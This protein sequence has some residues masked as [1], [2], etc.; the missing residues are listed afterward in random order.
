MS[1]VSL[2]ANTSAWSDMAGSV[3]NGERL[4]RAHALQILDASD[5][6]LLAILDAA[7]RVR[8]QHFGN[9]VQ[10]YYLKNAKS[11]LCP[12]DCTYCSQSKVSDAPIEKYAMLNAERLL[13]G[14][15]KAFESQART[16]C[17]VASGRG[18]SDREVDHVCNVV[19]EIKQKY[20]LHICAC[21][22]LLRPNQAARLKEAGVDRVNHNLNT[23]ERHH[24]AIVTTHTF[25]DRLETLRVCRDAGLELCTGM[26]VGMGESHE[27]VVDVAMKLAELEVASI[28]INFLNSIDGTP[29]EHHADLDPRYCLKVL[30]MF[31]L[32]NP[33][34]ELR[35]AGGREVNLRSLQAMGLY[36]ANSM[37]VSDYLTT[38]GQQAQED[39]SMIEDL[40]FEITAGDY[41]SATAAGKVRVPMKAVLFDASGEPAEVLHCGDAAV[42]EPAPG[43]LRV[44]MLASPINPSDLMFVR[45]NYTITAECP[46]SPGFEGVG[47]VEASGGGLR[48]KLFQGRRVVVMN[49]KGGNW[50]EQVVVPATQVIPVSSALSD[51]Q[52]ATF[53]VNPATAWVM[54]QEILRIPR[55]AWL[56]Q[57]AA[58]SALGHMIVRLGRECGF[59]TLNI[60]RRDAHRES[61]ER[62]GADSVVVFD[63]VTDSPGQLEE[64]VRRVSDSSD[65]AYAID[66]VGGETAT[67]VL[68]C[69]SSGGRLLLYGT[70]SDRPISFSPR[71]LMQRSAR[72]EGF[73]LGQFMQQQNLLFKLKLVR[74]ITRMIQSGILATSVGGNYR[75]EAITEAVTRSESRDSTGKI[76]L[77]FPSE[78]TS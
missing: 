40:G 64:H 33:A 8:R 60:I 62:A 13:E 21:L 29:L 70:L 14:A 49:T 78:R 20:G 72:V 57:T 47:I 55:G 6:E 68:N 51:E 50:A 25:Q 32:T 66:P 63:P 11:G 53:F 69:L 4:S 36:A 12:E 7:F 48:G 35:I 74:R 10:L 15:R 42:P 22:G 45:G 58:G 75:P 2:P 3:L 1:V 39:F 34:T 23:S 59:R 76:L 56:I 52:A 5:D 16:Y 44:R 27:D 61:L 67:A 38:T 19:R 73:W 28:P 24:D 71:I 9:S 65:V 41:E 37:F 26:I 54:T 30:A 46:Q 17:I 43:E 77:T 18:P 31:R